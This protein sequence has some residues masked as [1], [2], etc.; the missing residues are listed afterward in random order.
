MNEKYATYSNNDDVSA[1]FL[2]ILKDV[3]DF[4]N[5]I[6]IETVEKIA[7]GLLSADIVYLVGIGSDRIVAD[8][9]SNYLP[10]SGV[11]CIT[12]CEEG[13]A[14]KEK[15]LMLTKN[16]FI[17]M[18]SYPTLQS[19][20]YWLVEFVK[21]IGAKLALITDSKVTAKSLGVE[22]Y[23]TSKGTMQTFN[24]SYVMSMVVCDILLLK[25]RQRAPARIEHALEKYDELLKK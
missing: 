22:E 8:C 2:T 6:D 14:M 17:L 7:D 15:M 21:Q 3:K 13:L 25:L 11:R 19:D 5:I 23:I 18:S 24:N 10:L 1:Y 20:E 16:D 12:V 9:L 4:S